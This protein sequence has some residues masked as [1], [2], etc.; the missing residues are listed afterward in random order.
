VCIGVC[1]CIGTIRIKR[2][3]S[4]GR[5]R[6]TALRAGASGLAAPRRCRRRRGR[7]PRLRRAGRD[8]AGW[9]PDPGCRAPLA[10]G[11]GFRLADLAARDGTRCATWRAAD[12]SLL[13]FAPPAD[14]NLAPAA[15]HRL[16]RQQRCPSP[17]WLRGAGAS[18][19]AAASLPG[20]FWISFA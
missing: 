1:V 13:I 6:A 5:A 9:P 7:G 3:R 11:A 14:G 10:A 8:Q 18:G 15:S 12:A 17:R 2:G 20:G 19:S 4:S 16:L